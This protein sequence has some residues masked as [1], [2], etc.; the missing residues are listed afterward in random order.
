M[1]FSV[2]SNLTNGQVT[3]QPLMAADFE[4]LYAVASDPQIWEQHPDR[5]RY[6]REVFHVFFEGAMQSGG[7]FKVVDNT[8]EKILGSTRFYDY[9]EADNSIFI[10]YTFYAVNCWGKS[11]N[12]AVKTL[13]LN[14]IF[15]YVNRVRFHV[16]AGN[17]R[18]QI[19]VSRLGAQ[20][21]DEQQAINFGGVPTLKLVF[22]ITKEAWNEWKIICNF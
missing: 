8:T 18:S 4:A 11:T 20:K 13:M 1:N 6:K 12:Q 19:A 17:T 15:Q 7:A 16:G 14:Y 10:G 3:V 9:N 21:M 5:D 22:E 2:Q